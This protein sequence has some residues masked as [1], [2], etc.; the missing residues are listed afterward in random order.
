MAG[1]AGIDISGPS[2]QVSNAYI[3][4]TGTGTITPIKVDGGSTGA[5]SASDNLL[6]NVFVDGG[7]LSDI[8]SRSFGTKLNNVY[9]KGGT[10]GL[11]IGGDETRL[12]GCTFDGQTGTYALSIQ[13]GA[14]DCHVTGC[15]FRDITQDGIDVSGTSNVITGCYFDA[16]TGNEINDTG[17]TNHIL[18]NNYPITTDKRVFLSSDQ[19]VSVNTETVVTG[20]GGVAYPLGAN[21]ARKYLVECDVIAYRGVSLPALATVRI[22]NGTAGGLGDSVIRSMDSDIVATTSNRGLFMF[23]PFEITP[24]LNEKLTVSSEFLSAGGVVESGV[25]DKLDSGN[26]GYVL[27]PFSETWLRITLLD[28]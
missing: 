23:R 6:S 14:D 27:N 4:L 5:E 13:A 16:I 22:R 26:L 8:T 1:C 7:G 21:G 28:E 3:G 17:T 25:S 2:N 24:A 11:R 12:I 10:Q 19:A 9:F 20:M 15:S 18:S